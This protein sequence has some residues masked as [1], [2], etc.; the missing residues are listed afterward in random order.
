MQKK[1]IENIPRR[2]YSGIS[3]QNLYYPD[4]VVFTLSK[5]RRIYRFEI[6]NKERIA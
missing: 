3:N 4:W 5:I 1:Q 2:P 6:L